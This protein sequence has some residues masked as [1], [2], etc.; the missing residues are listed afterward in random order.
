MR[1]KT[2]A[3]L[4]TVLVQA[5]AFS[6]Y[7]Q[8]PKGRSH[9]KADPIS[10]HWEITYTIDGTTIVGSMDLKLEGDKITGKSF[11]EHTGPGTLSKGIWS[12]PQLSFT[13]DFE[14]HESIAVTGELKNAKLSGEFR[15]EGMVGAWEAVKKS[16]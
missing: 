16:E 2:F 15:T 6:V 9:G 12:K 8:S 7:A 5:L 10:G 3:I 4:A 11:T 13:M 1:W 14:K